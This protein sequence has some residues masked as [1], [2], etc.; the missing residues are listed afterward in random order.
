M[1]QLLLTTNDTGGYED[2]LLAEQVLRTVEHH[3]TRQ[4]YFLYW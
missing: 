2:A 4:P 3:D 1:M